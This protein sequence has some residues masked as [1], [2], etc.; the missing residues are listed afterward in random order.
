MATF[1]E[2]MLAKYEALPH[3]SGDTPLH[4]KRR[5]RR[6]MVAGY[7]PVI[8]LMSAKNVHRCNG[9]M[10]ESL[11]WPPFQAYRSLASR[12]WQPGWATT[13]PSRP[14]RASPSAGRAGG[15]G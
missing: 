10:Q 11:A 15:G 2:T 9:A 12:S 13:R 4:Y 7:P 3:S 6:R 5:H 14:R 8:R 1:T